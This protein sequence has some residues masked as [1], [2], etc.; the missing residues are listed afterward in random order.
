MPNEIRTFTIEDTGEVRVVPLKSL[1]KELLRINAEIIRFQAQRLG[2]PEL[3]RIAYAHANSIEKEV[4]TLWNAGCDIQDVYENVP[5]FLEYVTG[6]DEN[7]V[8]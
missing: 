1:T 2:D 5:G 3:I 6:E 4:D 8:T 7:V